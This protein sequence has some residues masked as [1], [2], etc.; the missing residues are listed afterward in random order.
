MLTDADIEMAELEERGNMAAA[1]VCIACEEALNP[2]DPKWGGSYTNPRYTATMAAVCC[3]PA[4]PTQ[5]YHV[6]CWDEMLADA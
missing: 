1:G 5:P 3:G 2:L 6:A 4:H